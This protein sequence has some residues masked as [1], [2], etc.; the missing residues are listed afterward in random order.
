MEIW[1]YSNLEIY[2]IFEENEFYQLKPLS[3]HNDTLTGSL[4]GL[5]LQYG[6]LPWNGNTLDGFVYRSDLSQMLFLLS[7]HSKYLMCC[8]FSKSKHQVYSNTN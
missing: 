2:R 8:L 4:S 1:I 6:S 7:Y 5:A 3:C